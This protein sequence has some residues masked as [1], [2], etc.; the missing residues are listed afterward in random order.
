[1]G[2]ALR[3]QKQDA[4][5]WTVSCPLGAEASDPGPSDWCQ[6]KGGRATRDLIGSYT[7]EL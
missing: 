4:Q 7:N 1:M 6:R 5:M 3:W 2:W